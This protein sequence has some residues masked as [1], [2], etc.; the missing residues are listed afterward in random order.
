[1]LSPNMKVV[2]SPTG[3][4]SYP[5]VMVCGEPQFHDERRDVLTNAPVVFEVLSPSAEACDRGEKFLRYRT[6]L[7]AL[8][9]YVLVSGCPQLQCRS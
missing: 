5:D 7:G 8:Q 3:L 2:T 4:F 1:M 9:E 6:Q